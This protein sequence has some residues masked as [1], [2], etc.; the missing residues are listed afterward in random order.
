MIQMIIII[1]YANVFNFLSRMIIWN[2][3]I[4]FEEI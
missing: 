2:N 3:V 1:Y 4:N